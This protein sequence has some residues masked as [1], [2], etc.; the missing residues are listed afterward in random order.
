M[1]IRELRLLKQAAPLDWVIM[2]DFNL[3]YNSKDKSNDRLDQRM[4]TRFRRA[5]NFLE[6]KEIQLVGR[7]YTWSNQQ[8]TPTM[9]RIDRAFCTTQWEEIYNNSILQSLASSSADFSGTYAPHECAL[10]FSE[11]GWEP[12][13]L[14]HLEIPFSKVEVKGVILSMPR[15]KARGPDGFIGAFFSSYWEVIKLDIMR[16]P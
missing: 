15:E 4:M 10:N 13:D 2:G 11:L 12:K 3:I 9:S 5:L 16:V 6:L 1:F 8:D 7:K 14:H